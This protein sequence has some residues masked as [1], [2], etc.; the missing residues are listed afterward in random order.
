VLTVSGK[1]AAGENWE[2][3]TVNGASLLTRPDG[4]LT[5]D[6]RRGLLVQPTN[7]GHVSRRQ[8]A[9]A[10]QLGVTLAWVFNE[11][12][13]VSM[14]YDFLYWNH[15]VRP[16]DQIDRQVNVGAI[17]DP[18]QFG[19]SPHPQMPFTTTGFWAQGLTGGVEV[20]F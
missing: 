18:G 17:G 1:F 20:S 3:V 7:I 2:E 9:V 8:F 13:R 15:V 19:N 10:P 6:P 4:R 12:F 11:H 5:F 14:G 16:G